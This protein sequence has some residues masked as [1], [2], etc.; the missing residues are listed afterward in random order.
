MDN[1]Y[2][3]QY[4]MRFNYL[5][6]VWM[7]VPGAEVHIDGLGQDGSISIANVLEILQSCDM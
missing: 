4:S 3:P 5:L 1:N 7:P 6:I 2:I